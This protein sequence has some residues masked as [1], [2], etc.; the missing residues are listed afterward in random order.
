[1]RV[2]GNKG[3]NFGVLTREEALEKAKELGFDLIEIA[4]TAV[5]PV[6][7]IMDFGKYLYQQ[8]KKARSAEKAHKTETKEIQVRI[9]ISPHDME[10]KAKRA[11]E[12]LKLG[13]RVKV[14]LILKGREKG[15]D[16][17][18]VR[19]RLDRFL[20]VISEKYKMADGPKSGPRGL[21]VIIEKTL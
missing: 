19:E 17:N 12:F 6:A 8:E 11:D 2:V 5:P 3:E 16:R 7:K 21:S 14:D 18:F 4:P 13:D 15:I 10:L 1:M 20:Q 9:N